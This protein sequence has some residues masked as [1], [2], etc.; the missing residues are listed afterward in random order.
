M[1][2]ALLIF[3]AAVVFAVPALL[4]MVRLGSGSRAPHPVVLRTLAAR[5]ERMAIATS[6][7]SR[8][9]AVSAKVESTRLSSYA[10]GTPTRQRP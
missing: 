4:G 5:P 1:K 7:R 10:R 8:G 9:R 3:C 2:A 6:Q